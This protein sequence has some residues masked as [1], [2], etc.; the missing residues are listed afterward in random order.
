LQYPA[1]EKASRK[2]ITAKINGTFL[3]FMLHQSPRRNALNALIS[4]RAT[5]GATVTKTN[6]FKILPK[7]NIVYA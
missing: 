7:N 5:G 3:R 1:D 4:D 6:F 2:A